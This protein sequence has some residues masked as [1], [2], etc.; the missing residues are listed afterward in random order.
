MDWDYIENLNKQLPQMFLHLLL[1]LPF[2]IRA[3]RS[4]PLLPQ[5]VLD[6]WC[7]MDML[8]FTNWYYTWEISYI[9]TAISHTPIST[10]LRP[11]MTSSKVVHVNQGLWN[12]QYWK[13]TEPLHSPWNPQQTNK[14]YHYK[15]QFHV[16]FWT[17]LACVS[18]VKLH[19]KNIKLTL[20]L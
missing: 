18:K 19:Y 7:T 14:E 6:N 12:Q 4:T 15:Q 13:Q 10:T 2:V 3:C 11:N 17:D 1:S 16:F 5:A 20:K 8:Y 9:H